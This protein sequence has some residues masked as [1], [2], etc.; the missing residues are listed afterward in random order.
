MATLPTSEDIMKWPLPNYVNPQTRRP[1]V[2]GVEI[3]VTVLP[4]LFVACRFYSRTVIVR[5]LGWDDWLMLI[6]TIIS[7]ATNI[8]TIISTGPEYQTGYHL[9]DLRPEILINPEQA[10]QVSQTCIFPSKVN[11]RFC[12]IIIAF[13]LVWGIVSFFVTLFQCA[14]VESYWLVN[15]PVRECLDVRVLYYT[16]SGLNILT[17]FLIF[18][19][20]AKDLASVQ[21]SLRQRITLIAM[22]CLGVIIC[23]AGVCRVWY[24]SIYVATWD[25]LCCKP[26]FSKMVPSVFSATSASYS[27]SRSGN[28]KPSKTPKMD[29]DGQPFPFQIV[30]EEGYEVRYGTADGPKKSRGGNY[31]GTSTTVSLGGKGAESGDDGRSEDSREWIMMKDD[32]R[33]KVS[34][35]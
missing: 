17:D 3:P 6:A 29:V 7:T 12:H 13:E 11:K 9:Y 25:F 4:I 30:K 22:F 23:I 33:A 16:P 10:V 1:L 35:V 26:L 24:I 15:A 34:A 31:S 21:I 32:L 8:M 20:P 27:N 14:P 2:Q 19:W 18:L 28:K 5:A